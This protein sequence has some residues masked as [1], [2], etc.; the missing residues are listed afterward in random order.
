MIQN[1][2]EGLKTIKLDLLSFIKEN[3]CQK[4][5]LLAK[6]TKVWSFDVYE[7]MSMKATGLSG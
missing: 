7:L 3:D 6:L 4:K 1:K 5:R 2:K